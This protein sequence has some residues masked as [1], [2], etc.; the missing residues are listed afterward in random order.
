M[1]PLASIQVRIHYA[2]C[3]VGR[4]FAKMFYFVDELIVFVVPSEDWLLSR[5]T[6]SFCKTRPAG[7]LEYII[8][9]L[10]EFRF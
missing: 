9:V 3:L 7:V 5:L 2:G 4:L 6:I 8:G 10:L 1:L